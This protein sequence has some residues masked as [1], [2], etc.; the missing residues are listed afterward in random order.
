MAAR[1]STRREG[2][3]DEQESISCKDW[4][5]TSI[6]RGAAGAAFCVTGRKLRPASDLDIRSAR[7]RKDCTRWQLSRG[8]GI[9]HD[10]VPGRFRGRRPSFTIS[11]SCA[12]GRVC[13]QN[14]IRFAAEVCSR[15][16]VGLAELCSTLL[17]GGFCLTAR[18][19]GAGAGQLSGSAAGC[20]NARNRA[21]GHCGGTAGSF[22][23]RDKPE[24]STASLCS[25][26]R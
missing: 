21:S 18:R 22:G 24:R 16:L 5:A 1:A 14:R 11:L 4:A 9:T 2:L 7:R 26:G 15:A 13:R 6:R 17:S 25:I 20:V 3:R 12:G 19:T 8:P 23:N 10:L